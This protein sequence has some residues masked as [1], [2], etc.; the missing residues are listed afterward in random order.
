VPDRSD[1][2]S[3]T[4]PSPRV[5]FKFGGTTLGEPERFRTVIGLLR[6]AAA[7]DRVVAIVSA[8]SQVSR[9]LSAAMEAFA[10]RPDGTAVVEDLLHTLRDRHQSQAEAVLSNERADEYTAL[11][12][13]H[14]HALQ[15]RFAEVERF[16]FTPAA[17]D[18]V[19]ATGEQL[20]VPMVTL[21]LRDA[22]LTAP[23]CDAT[24]LVVTDDTFGEASVNRLATTE[25]VRPWY[26]GLSA[27]AV[28]VVAG[29]I[30]GTTGGYTT[31]LGFEGS[32][33][34]ASL[35]ARILG[36]DCVTRY[37]DVDG[38]YTDD[39]AAHADAERLDRLSMEAAFAMTESGDLGMHPKTL[40]PLADADIPMQVRSIV[41]PERRGTCILPEGASSDAFW[42]RP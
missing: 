5:V 37:T 2:P 11:L 4:I 17:R 16:G 29:F 33:Y 12:N 34:S 10:T 38:L 36:A 39:P 31:T 8:L 19:L 14:L 24:R 26:R 42:P 40:R 23:H 30:G 20:S 21:A 25:R 27:G 28:P 32:D 35:F 7:A 15:Q 9:Q 41:E 22:G 3:E 1:S 13:E 18:A 6:E